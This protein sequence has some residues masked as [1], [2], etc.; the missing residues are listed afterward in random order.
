MKR[1]LGIGCLWVIASPPLTAQVFDYSADRD[2]ALRA[3]DASFHR[4]DRPLAAN[5]YAG[6]VRD[7]EA[8]AVRAEAAW[9]MGDLQAAN[10]YFRTAVEIDPE[11]ARSRARWGRLFLLTHQNSE[12]IRLF[13]ESLELDPDYLPAKLG[14]AAV[15]AGRFEDRA[16][17][18]VEEVL[19]ADP[20]QIEAHLLRAR[21]SLEDGA[22]EPA[23]EALGEALRS[24]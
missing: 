18:L 3:C 7:S 17:A 12:A 1:W 21:M 8:A 4:G 2:T 15:A 23:E 22:L 10:A 24:A 14:L 6:L 13:Q 5:C 20:A 11:S 16:R 19:E 9:R